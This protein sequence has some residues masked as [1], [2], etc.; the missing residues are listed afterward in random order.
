[1]IY[2]RRCNLEDCDILYEWSNDKIVR[3]NAFNTSHILYS[4]HI[5]WFTKSLESSKRIIFICMIDAIPV[6]MIRID[7][8]NS[9]AMISYLIDKKY[10]G[11]GIGTYMVKLLQET[12]EGDMG[13]DRLIG[14]VKKDN[15]ASCKV[16][17]KLGYDNFEDVDF[18]KYILNLQ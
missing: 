7:I 11:R 1:M 16:F 17:E 5:N 8:E 3:Q 18:N 12:I 14:L 10:R 13:I 4:D 15:I 2:L 6:G 9:E